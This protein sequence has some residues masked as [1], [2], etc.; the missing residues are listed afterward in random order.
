[1]FTVHLEEMEE[2]RRKP[3][4]KPILKR[5]SRPKRFKPIS[6][7]LTAASPTPQRTS[8]RFTTGKM[9]SLHHNMHQPSTT[10]SM[11]PVPPTPQQ[12]SY[13]RCF[14]QGRL[15]PVEV[16]RPYRPTPV[17]QPP[18]E[19][20]PRDLPVR[21]P[22]FVPRLQLDDNSANS[23]SPL[24][25][26]TPMAPRQHSCKRR[27][28]QG[29]LRPLEVTGD[30]NLNNNFTSCQKKLAPIPPIARWPLC[31][32]ANIPSSHA[33]PRPPMTPQAGNRPNTKT[34]AKDLKSRESLNH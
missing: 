27:L 18:C 3:I 30:L 14:P 16:G 26:I 2:N 21:R 13:R 12:E 28:P 29:R 8:E 24:V 34:E 9:P 19:V 5:P 31:N 17:S 6:A 7:R 20:A 10:K 11:T 32:I 1:M 33:L 4:S 22:P 25:P 23:S 15:R